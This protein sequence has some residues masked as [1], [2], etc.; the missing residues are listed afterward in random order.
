MGYLCSSYYPRK[1]GGTF[2]SKDGDRV[3]Y[4]KE[5]LL[6]PFFMLRLNLKTILVTGS[7][8]FIGFHVTKAL[9]D[10]GFKVIGLDNL[11]DYYD[12]NLKKIGLITSKNIRTLYFI[13][14][15]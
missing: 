8:G 9:L 5:N 14:R 2:R 15:I 12:I 7:C 4:N 11:N 1:A 10:K 6:N 13:Y 3:I